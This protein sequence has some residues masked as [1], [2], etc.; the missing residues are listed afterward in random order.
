MNNDK[1]INDIVESLEYYLLLNE[2]KGVV[3]I[4]KFFVESTIKSLKELDKN[5]N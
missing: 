4:P 1:K 3:Y 2:E 5:A